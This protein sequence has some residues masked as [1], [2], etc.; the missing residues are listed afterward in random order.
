M[1]KNA[2]ERFQQKPIKRTLIQINLVT[3]G[4]ASLHR[5]RREAG[6]KQESIACSSTTGS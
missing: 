6:M 2:L 4:T 1:L 3:T 5:L